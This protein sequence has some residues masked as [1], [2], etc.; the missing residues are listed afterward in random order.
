[1]SRTALLVLPL[2][3]YVVKK[4][5]LL[6]LFFIVSLIA[7]P[8]VV[9]TLSRGLA[10]DVE[11]IDRFWMWKSAID[12]FSE[13]PQQFIFGFDLSRPLPVEIPDPLSGLHEMQTSN[14]ESSGFYA[15]SFHSFW[16][17][18]I[19]TWG[20]LI[21]GLVFSTVYYKLYKSKCSLG[22]PLI[23][24]TVFC[25]FTMGVFYV[26]HLS[27]VLLIMLMTSLGANKYA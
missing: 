7:I 14:K 17:R 9:S 16:L 1:M 5:G 20:I 2:I 6:N 3:Y 22:M 25:G 27:V 8:V 19:S 26:G 12:I 24:I 21:V 23:I 4:P 11:S 13:N 18:V 10:L 15:F